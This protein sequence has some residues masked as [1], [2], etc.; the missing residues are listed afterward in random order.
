MFMDGDHTS[1]TGVARGLDCGPKWTATGIIKLITFGSGFRV[2]GEHRQGAVTV[3]AFCHTYNTILLLHVRQI[4]ED[5]LDAV[6]NIFEHYPNNCGS[7]DPQLS[8]TS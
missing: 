5:L 3:P 4:I 1:S 7:S 2:A 6:I 8:S